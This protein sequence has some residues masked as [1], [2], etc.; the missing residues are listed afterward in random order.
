MGLFLIKTPYI[1]LTKARAPSKATT[2]PT[3]I[4]NDKL[5]SRCNSL[6][7]MELGSKRTIDNKWFPIYSFHHHTC[8]VSKLLYKCITFKLQWTGQTINFL[9][10]HEASVSRPPHHPHR[11]FLT[12]FHWLENAYEQISPACHQHSCCPSAGFFFPSTP[13]FTHQA[14]QQLKSSAQ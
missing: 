6:F 11:D 7:W 3:L 9:G 4:F 8:K 13:R 14:R 5:E 2:L 1:S 10:T 12:V